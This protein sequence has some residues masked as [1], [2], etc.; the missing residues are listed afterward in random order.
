[1]LARAGLGKPVL[2]HGF[3]ATV[4]SFAERAGRQGFSTRVGL[5]DGSTLPDGTRHR[6]TP[7]SSRLRL[8]EGQVASAEMAWVAG[9]RP[10]PIHLVRV[11]EPIRT[12]LTASGAE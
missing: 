8:D 6:R 12:F 3:D 4:W 7:P 9:Q 1:V 2:L 10:R 11:I 5:E